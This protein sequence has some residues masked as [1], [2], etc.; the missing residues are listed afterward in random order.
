[1]EDIKLPGLHNVAN[2]MAA[3]IVGKILGLDE[4]MMAKALVSFKGLRHRIELVGKINQVSFYEDSQST[5]PYSTASALDSFPKDKIILIAGGYKAIFEEN[6]YAKMVTK[7]FSPQVKAVLLIGKVA[8]DIKDLF[9]KLKKSCSG[10]PE[11]VKNCKN[12]NQ[13]AKEAW[14]MA[15]PGDIVLL[16]PGAESFGEFKDYRDRGEQF[17]KLIKKLK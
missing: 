6:D 1:L 16:S 4:K 5:A 10:G 7:F 14:G 13:A 9:F 12:L 2:I 11:L 3:I 8:G 17:K 15:A